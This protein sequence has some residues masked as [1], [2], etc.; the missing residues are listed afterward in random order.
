MLFVGSDVSRDH[1][2]LLSSGADEHMMSL[3][4]GLLQTTLLWVWEG[5]AV[6]GVHTGLGGA[7]PGEDLPG[8][9]VATSSSLLI[10]LTWTQEKEHVVSGAQK[11]APSRG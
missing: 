9:Q 3:S 4:L 7:R 2:L 1:H 10:L 11:E 5:V 6:L 8:H